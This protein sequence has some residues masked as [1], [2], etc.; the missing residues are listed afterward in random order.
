LVAH[1]YFL[2]VAEGAPFVLSKIAYEGIWG[3]GGGKGCCRSISVPPNGA[4]NG[5][6]HSRIQNPWE[7]NAVGRVRSF[8]AECPPEDK[9]SREHM[10]PPDVALLT[11]YMIST[12]ITR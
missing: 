8:Q 6:C 10:C 2:S 12:T 4:P 9:Y 3:E 7:T 11:M 5:W 1:F